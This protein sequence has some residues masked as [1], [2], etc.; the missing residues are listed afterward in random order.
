[1]VHGCIGAWGA[2]RPLDIAW[3][4]QLTGGEN[5]DEEEEDE[6]N[7][8]EDEARSYLYLVPTPELVN[9]SIP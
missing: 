5:Q 7:D 4:A 1:M 2:R 6:D 8:D 9:P 3:L